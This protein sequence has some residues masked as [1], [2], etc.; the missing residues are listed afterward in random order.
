MAQVLTELKSNRVFLLDDSH[1]I[2]FYLNTTTI[3]N[4]CHNLCVCACVLCVPNE[5]YLHVV[6]TRQRR[7]TAKVLLQVWSLCVK[8]RVS[9]DGVT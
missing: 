4:H 5:Y 3:I 6:G 7:L 9:I 1:E 8:P 2:N